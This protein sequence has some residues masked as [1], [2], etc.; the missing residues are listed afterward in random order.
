[1]DKYL[2]DLATAFLKI[3]PVRYNMQ[4]INQ[5]N[6]V[7]NQDAENNFTSYLV[8]EFRRIMEEQNNHYNGLTMDF[9]IMKLRVNFR[10]DFVLHENN[11]SRRKQIFIGEVKTSTR[12]NIGGDLSNLLTAVNKDL[13]FENAVMMVINK[14]YNSTVREIINF[15]QENNLLDSPEIATKIWLFHSKINLTKNLPD[16]KIENILSVYYNN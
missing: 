4:G 10:P 16:F 5:R 13:R 12:A 1:M 9:D 14:S 8:A 7:Y 2:I 3:D 6:E 15:I 11:I